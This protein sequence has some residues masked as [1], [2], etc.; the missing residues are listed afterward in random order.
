M[1]YSELKKK[2]EVNKRYSFT[3]RGC[4]KGV[5]ETFEDVRCT[6]IYYKKAMATFEMFNGVKRNVRLISIIKFNGEKVYL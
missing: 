4:S 3:F 5:F 6:N 1:L 2:I